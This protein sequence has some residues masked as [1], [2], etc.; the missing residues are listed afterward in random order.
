[1]VESSGFGIMAYTLADY[2]SALQSVGVDPFLTQ[3]YLDNAGNNL[4]NG[5]NAITPEAYAQQMAEAK[6]NE[7]TYSL[8]NLEAQQA[9]KMA[10]KE[11]G[12]G[13]LLSILQ[14]NPITQ[15][16]ESAFLGPILGGGTLGAAGAG[17]L[18]GAGTSAA[19]GGNP[20]TGALEGGALAGA[21]A[22]ILNNFGDITSDLGI[23]GSDTAGQ[24]FG[25]VTGLNSLLDSSGSS[26]TNDLIAANQP[27]SSKNFFGS[28]MSV[29]LG[30]A[31][32]APSGPSSAFSY[33]LSGN[34]V[35]GSPTGLSTFSSGGGAVGGIGG[36]AASAANALGPSSPLDIG[37]AT[38]GAGVTGSAPVTTQGNLPWLNSSA[39]PGASSAE[40]GFLNDA[41]NSAAT[42]N[43]SAPNIGGGGPATASPSSSSIDKFMD[44]P[45]IGSFGKMLAA[46]AA[47][48]IAGGGLLA[49]VVQ[50]N[51]PVKGESQVNAAA[52]ADTAAGA[53][54]QSYLQN[55]TLPPGAQASIHQ[56][57]QSQK[58][59]IKS[60]FAQMGNSGSSAEQQELAAVDQW[61]QGQGSQLALQLLNSG[62]S[63]SQMGAALYSDISK[64]AL[65]Q[66]QSLASSIGAFASSFSGGTGTGAN[67]FK[68]V[69]A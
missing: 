49:N 69:A 12:F 9:A 29:R 23:T 67:G 64:N 13:G 11:T 45:G 21:G 3:G 38:S 66:D 34:Q 28:D 44:K 59:A 32:T 7:S 56:A 42:T 15:G 35:A 53:Q 16:I 63:Q 33:D 47:P 52:A 58:A 20:I 4:G 39:V 55:G 51:K 57:A 22:G 54:N 37:D 50:G 8:S 68:L 25:Q 30:D 48:L 5:A 6:K 62:I 27:D 65:A 26:G 43:V 18:I 14:A 24:S 19:T 60:R 10:N 2:N 40:Q 41:S 36:N 17:S 31:G 61:A 1:M 46:N